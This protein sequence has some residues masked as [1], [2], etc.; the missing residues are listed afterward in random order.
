MTD[1]NAEPRTEQEVFEEIARQIP[2]S[3]ALACEL[4]S[5]HDEALSD[6]DQIWYDRFETRDRDWLV[7]INAMEEDTVIEPLGV[8]DPLEAG[9]VFIV[10][11]DTVLVR[12]LPVGAHWYQ[13]PDTG[14]EVSDEEID[15]YWDDEIIHAVFNR[16]TENG[17]DLPNVSTYVSEN[18]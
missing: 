14:E 3:Y 7:V 6:L 18:N 4:P 8:S 16:L 13:D 12:L 1:N 2:I 5:I 15:A 9:G 10:C 17:K 11:D